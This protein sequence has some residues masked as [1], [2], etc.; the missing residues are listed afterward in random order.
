MARYAT[1]GY[2]LVHIVDGT[3][4]AKTTTTKLRRVAQHDDL[5][6]SAN[7]H[8]IKIGFQQVS[9]REAILG[10]DTIH[11]DKEFT[12]RIILQLTLGIATNGRERRATHDT[13]ELD[14]LDITIFRENGRNVQRR[15]DNR[16]MAVI[17]GLNLACEILNRSTRSDDNRVVGL[18]K[19]NGTLGDGCLL[20]RILTLLDIYVAVVDIGSNFNRLTMSAIERARLFQNRKVLADGYLRDIEQHTQLRYAD[21]SFGL[22]LA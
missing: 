18:D 22:N 11:T 3:Y 1:I 21:L 13:A 20:G 7:H 15:C 16:Q 2:Y 5:L 4:T 19:P 12:T 6:G 9:G 17:V 14:N 10:V 8:T